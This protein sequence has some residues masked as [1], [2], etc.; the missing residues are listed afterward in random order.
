MHRFCGFR[1]PRMIGVLM[2]ILYLAVPS[3]VLAQQPQIPGFYGSAP[4]LPEIAADTLPEIDTGGLISGISGLSQPQDNQLVVH[5][6]QENAI[7]DFI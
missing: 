2:L 3:Q 6:N 1:K 7:I 5:Q 4:D